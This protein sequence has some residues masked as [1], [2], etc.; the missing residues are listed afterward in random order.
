MAKEGLKPKVPEVV[1][2]SVQPPEA[3]VVSEPPPEIIVSLQKDA[4]LKVR[5][6]YKCMVDPHTGLRF[7][8]RPTEVYKLTPWVQEQINTKKLVVC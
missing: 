5:A 8:T 2:A 3:A 4:V 1:V 7:E 6:M